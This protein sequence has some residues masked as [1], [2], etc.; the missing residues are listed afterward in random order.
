M[1]DDTTARLTLATA[2]RTNGTTNGT[3][4]DSAGTGNFFRSSM[5]LVVGGTVTDGTHTVTLQDSDDGTTFA[6]V[7]SDQVQGS[8]AAVTTGSVQRQAYLG[9]KRYLRAS[10]VVSGATTGGTVTAVVLLA[11][12]SGAPVS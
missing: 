2:L 9:A 8:L 3:A 10:V 11:S 1:Y 5:L 12:G 7:P 4:V 6:A